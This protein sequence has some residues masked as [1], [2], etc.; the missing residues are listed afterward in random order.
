MGFAQTTP[1]ED[2]VE[3]EQERPGGGAGIAPTSLQ[4]RSLQVI[5]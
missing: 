3:A 5:F 2:E 1:V 4:G